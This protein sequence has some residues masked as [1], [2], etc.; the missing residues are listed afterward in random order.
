M[1]TPHK[2][3]PATAHIQQGWPL[4]G[5]H[6]TSSPIVH[7]CAANTLYIVP[8]LP[9][10]RGNIPEAGLRGLLINISWHTRKQETLLTTMT[11]PPPI[12]ARSWPGICS[13]SLCLMHRGPAPP[14]PTQATQVTGLGQAGILLIQDS[15]VDAD[16]VSSSEQQTTG[17]GQP[18][19]P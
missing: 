8:K 17:A 2:L 16:K 14:L 15:V 10:R 11:T 4:A 13:W 1:R 5:V 3:Q 12:L 6:A 9:N 19:C 18:K 7:H